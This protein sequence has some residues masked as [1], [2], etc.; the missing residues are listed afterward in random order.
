VKKRPQN[1]NKSVEFPIITAKKV[2]TFDN[3]CAMINPKDIVRK[4]IKFLMIGGSASAAQ[5]KQW[6]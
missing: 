5:K 2:L 1:P 3:S 6:R 4:L